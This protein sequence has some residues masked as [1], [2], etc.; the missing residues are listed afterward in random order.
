MLQ[1]MSAPP[2]PAKKPVASD[3][4]DSLMYSDNA[5]YRAIIQEQTEERIF[6]KL[7]QQNEIQG[8]TQSVISEL[9]AEYPELSDRDNALTI[10]SVEILNSLPQHERA[11]TTAYRYAVK[12]AAEELAVKPRSKRGDDEF[13]GPSYNAY[14]GQQ[15]RREK[16]EKQTIAEISPLAE[17][18]GLDMNDPAVAKRIA[19]RTKRSFKELQAPLRVR[20]TK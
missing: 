6:Q 17:A 13:M 1:R 5:R 16:S 19:E 11:T 12:Q 20:K 4:L 10:K 3:D 14:G 9:A 7:N 2:A 15:R 8:R 18:M